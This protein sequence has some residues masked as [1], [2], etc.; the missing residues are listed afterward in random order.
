MEKVFDFVEGYFNDE[1]K[2]KTIVYTDGLILDIKESEK[3]PA[4]SIY[5]DSVLYEGKINNIKVKQV[6]IKDA[7]YVLTI[8][9]VEEIIN[10]KHFYK[11]KKYETYYYVTDLSVIREVN[12]TLDM[13]ASD[14]DIIDK[15][16]IPNNVYYEDSAKEVYSLKRVKDGN[17]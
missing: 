5:I 7:N 9:A 4:D 10:N 1:K 3:I 16:Y 15:F 13:V 14:L 12:K 17:R 6:L 11:I 8:T 2:V